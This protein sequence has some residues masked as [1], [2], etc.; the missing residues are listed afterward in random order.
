M[1]SPTGERY[2]FKIRHTHLPGPRPEDYIYGRCGCFQVRLPP[3]CWVK[4]VCRSVCVG[5]FEL[6]VKSN[7]FM[8]KESVCLFL[9]V[10]CEQ[11]AQIYFPSCLFFLCRFPSYKCGSW[12]LSVVQAAMAQPEQ[13]IVSENIYSLC[14]HAF[15]GY[16][17]KSFMMSLE[18][19]YVNVLRNRWLKKK[20]LLKLHN[21]PWESE[22]FHLCF[23]RGATLPQHKQKV[24]V[25]FLNGELAYKW[26]LFKMM[27]PDEFPN[28]SW[29]M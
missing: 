15:W 1:I 21:F 9:S 23:F 28:A 19:V 8:C 17:I 2:V 18:N 12:C 25:P 6:L 22:C 3:E 29:A 4:C 10:F 7:K 20:M 11:P 13:Q 16:I 26:T 27:P 5:G 24:H 14:A